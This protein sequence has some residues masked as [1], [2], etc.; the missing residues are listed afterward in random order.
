MAGGHTRDAHRW[1]GLRIGV[2]CGLRPAAPLAIRD[3]TEPEAA[4]AAGGRPRA[5]TSS[6]PGYD[7]GAGPPG[8][9]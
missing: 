9:S 4:G 2:G 6:T 8:R 1:R 3:G 5:R 7:R